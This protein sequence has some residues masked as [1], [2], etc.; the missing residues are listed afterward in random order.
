MQGT[1]R[2]A[3]DPPPIEN[4]VSTN[5]QPQL[6]QE[7]RERALTAARR[8][9]WL[10]DDGLNLGL[11]LEQI[12]LALTERLDAQK[13]RIEELTRIAPRKVRYGN[14]WVIWRCPDDMVPTL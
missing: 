11:P 2:I 7:D 6:S 4:E 8:R 10:V 3:A 1:D 13:T 12:I 5:A 14:E 9:D